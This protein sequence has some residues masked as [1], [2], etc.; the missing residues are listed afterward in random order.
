[1]NSL[2]VRGARVNLASRGAR[3]KEKAAEVIE[4]VANKIARFGW[5]LQIYAGLSI[6]AA[7]AKL[8]RRLPVEVVFDHMGRPDAKLGIGQPGFDELLELM[9]TGR[10]WVKLSGEYHNSPDEMGNQDVKRIARTL[11]DANPDRVLWGSDWPHL[12]KHVMEADGTPPPAIYRAID[13]GLL[14][15]NLGNWAVETSQIERILVSN[16]RALYQLPS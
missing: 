9:S 16:P 3:P 13:Y 6:I 5:H 12:G 15:S 10:A 4:F 8:I 1:M 14:L 2:G 7:Q 11:V